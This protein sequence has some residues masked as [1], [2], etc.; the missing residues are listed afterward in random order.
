MNIFKTGARAVRRIEFHLLTT[1][2]PLLY[3]GNTLSPLDI[4]VLIR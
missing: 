2:R 1:F 4:A 3:T